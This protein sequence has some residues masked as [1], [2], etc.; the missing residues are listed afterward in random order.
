MSDTNID[1]IFSDLGEETTEAQGF[2]ASLK[3]VIPSGY[4]QLCTVDGEV[5]A[6]KPFWEPAIEAKD[7]LLDAV[8]DD[9]SIVNIKSNDHDWMYGVF[10]DDFDA[11]LLF[12]LP[13]ISFDFTQKKSGMEL[14]QSI[15]D[16]VALKQEYDEQ[17]T[18]KEQAV[19]QIAM[20]KQQHGKLIED[21]Y[22][23]YRLS[24]EKEKQYARKLEN[25][26]AFQTAEL[27]EKNMQLEE[28]SRLQSDFLANMS[29]ELRTP[30]NAIIGFTGLLTETEL[31]D[32]QIDYTR[33]ISQ[34]SDSL[35]VLINDILDLAK[36]EAGKLDLE[37]ELYDLKDVIENVVAMFKLPAESKN[38]ALNYEIDPKVPLA[39]IGDGHRLK[40][41]LV[42]LTGNSLKFTEKGSISILVDCG[43]Q[44][45]IEK[46]TAVRFSVKDTGIGIAPDR[47]RAIF[48]KFTQADGT[49]T[50]KY[51]GTGLGLAICD[52]LVEMMG[53][54]ISIESALGEGSNFYFTLP[55]KVQEGPVK[56]IEEEV[57]GESGST[58]EEIQVGSSI[59]L[60]EDN[61]VNQR[62]ASI[63]I[64]KQGYDLEVASDG[65]EALEQIKNNKFDAV[66]MD[67]QMPNMDGMTATK[68]IRELEGD[69]SSREQYASLQGRENLLPIIGLTAHARKEDEKA[70][71]DVGMDGF[72]TKPL[73]RE[74]MLETLQAYMPKKKAG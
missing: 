64:K 46:G 1:E 18:E 32:E 20:L 43:D 30:M 73:N 38:V 58:T 56:H 42:N 16:H 11:V 24:Q 23:Q 37:D 49:T 31:T 40:Q 36:I 70:C 66:L 60:V 63:I 62:L 10:I 14:L 7:S 15:V 57:A 65:L 6:K 47:Q 27:R 12:T 50:R 26:I 5:L 34:S 19:R 22:R 53:G 72:L 48:D 25:E 41:I 8:K 54:I 35:L 3:D 51:G 44:M 59:L 9:G 21:N 68:K 39:I 67:I 74:K 71:Y 69:S 29:H 13:D 55:M 52:Q 33:T 17:F 2:L 61:L 28:F 4:F 45:G